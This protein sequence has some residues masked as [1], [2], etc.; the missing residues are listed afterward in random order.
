MSRL[1]LALLRCMA[2]RGQVLINHSLTT[3]L[4]YTSLHGVSLTYSL[5]TFF[6]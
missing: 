6:L 2:H 3:I 1:L 5:K 4:F